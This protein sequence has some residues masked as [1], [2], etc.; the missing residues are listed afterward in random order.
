MAVKILGE[1]EGLRPKAWILA[2]ELAI[3][4]MDGPNTDREIIK[5]TAV[6]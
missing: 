3:N 2:N 6:L 1:A 4:T 5:T